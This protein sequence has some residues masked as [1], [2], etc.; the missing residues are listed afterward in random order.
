MS[1]N[2]PNI[3]IRVD[4]QKDFDQFR[5][6]LSPI[7]GYAKLRSKILNFYPKLDEKI[8]GVG[9]ES[10]CAEII[11]DMYY[12]FDATIRDIV[13]V[14]EKEFVDASP[15]FDALAK[16]MAVPNLCEKTF[17]CIPTFLPFS[18]IDDKGNTFFFSIASAIAGN[19]MKLYRAVNVGVHEISHFI[20]FEQMAVWIKKNN[21]TSFNNATTHYFKEGLTAAIMDQPEFRAFFGYERYLGNEELHELSISHK[22]QVTNIVSFFEREIFS[23]GCDYQ[24]TLGSALDMFLAEQDKFAKKWDEWNSATSKDELGEYRKPVE[25]G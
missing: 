17:M 1:N 5:F 16:Y 9:V 15:V 19:P 25:L 8:N 2:N 13:L 3:I 24:Q 21:R 23:K 12:R 10:A 6:F 20:F 11:P 4:S 22:G 7:S 18:P 14:I